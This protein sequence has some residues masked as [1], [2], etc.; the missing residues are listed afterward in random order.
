M[1]EFTLVAV[2][3]IGAFWLYNINQTLQRIE[4][5]LRDRLPDPDPD[6]DD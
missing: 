6:D 5:V 1:S 3:L 2:I 4:Q